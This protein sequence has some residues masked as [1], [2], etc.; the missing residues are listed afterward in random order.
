MLDPI[1]GHRVDVGSVR[2]S[3]AVSVGTQAGRNR[4]TFQR[5]DCSRLVRRDEV[6]QAARPPLFDKPV[7]QRVAPRKPERA[8]RRHAARPRRG[9]LLDECARLG[10]TG[11]RPHQPHLLLTMADKVEKRPLGMR[12]GWQHRQRGDTQHGGQQGA[13]SPP[14]R[15]CL[16]RAH[17]YPPGSLAPGASAAREPMETRDREENGLNASVRYKG[18]VPKGGHGPGS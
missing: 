5:L 18:S 6:R 9:A 2:R 17:G 7:R 12:R 11:I 3:I 8:Q 15:T 1:A 10:H 14:K 4:E 16:I 13:S